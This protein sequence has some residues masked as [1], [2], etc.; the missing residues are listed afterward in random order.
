MTVEVVLKLLGL[1]SVIA[2]GWGASRFGVFGTPEASRALSNAAFLLFGPALLF[3]SMAT[4]DF[5][6]SASQLLLAYYGT[7]VAGMAAVRW[8]LRRADRE[9]RMHAA[10]P[11]VRAVTV[12]F[13]NGVQVGIPMASVLFG[14]AGLQLHL[15][16]VSLHAL[17]LLSACTVWAEMDVAHAQARQDGRA[18]PL[19]SLLAGTARN[20]LIHPVVLPVLLGLAWNA[21]GLPI[22]SLIDGTLALL[23]QAMVPLCLVLIGVSLREY[24]LGTA[25]IPALRVAALKLL[26]LPALV[27]VVVGFGLGLRGLPLSVVVMFAAL[28][29]GSNPLLFANRYGTLEAETTAAIVLST[30]AYMLTAPLWLTVLAALG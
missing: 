30:G 18:V 17:V 4:M 9:R 5:D 12:G 22:P 29:T 19:G 1:F 26:A 21:V 15:T 13:G 10:A 14:N 20:A 28:P 25:W 27:L 8:F 2:T 7:A 6:R 24:G 16:I 23:G 11:S 3:R